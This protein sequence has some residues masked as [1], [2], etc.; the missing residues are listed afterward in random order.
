MFVPLLLIFT[1]SD[2]NLRQQLLSR[3]EDR[4]GDSFISIDQS[5]Y[6]I[7]M[8]GDNPDNEANIIAGICRDIQETNNR[9]YSEEDTIYICCSAVRLNYRPGDDNYNK[10]AILNIKDRI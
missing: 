4:Y 7:P 1:V 5:T 2:D 6:S 3:L 10:L 9:T 8:I